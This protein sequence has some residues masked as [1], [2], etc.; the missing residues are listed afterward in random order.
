MQGAGVSVD[1]GTILCVDD[2]A[3]LADLIARFLEHEK[4]GFQTVTAN[5][6]AEART[7]L[8]ERDVDCIVCDYRMPEEDGLAFLRDLRESGVDLPFI[9]YTAQGSE[10]V[11]SDAIA[12]GVTDYLQKRPDRNQFE[13]L[14]NRI[15]RW[16]AEYRANQERELTIERMTEAIIE[17]DSDWRFTMVDDRAAEYLGLDRVSTLGERIWDVLPRATEAEFYHACETVLETGEPATVEE[18]YAEMDRWFSID[19][20][21]GV[22]DGL[23]IYFKDVSEQKLRERRQAALTETLKELLQASTPEEACTVVSE[24]AAPALPTATLGIALFDDQRISLELRTATGDGEDTIEQLNLLREGGAAWEAVVEGDVVFV[25]VDHPVGDEPAVS[26]FVVLPLG[27]HGAILYGFRNRVESTDDV[28]DVLY[29]L[30]N[31]LHVALDRLAKEAQLRARDDRLE[32]QNRVLERL[33]R[34]NEVIRNIH[35]RLIDAKSRADV[36]RAIC[37]ELGDSGQYRFVWIGVLDRKS[38]RVVPKA[39]AGEEKGYLDAIDLALSGDETSDWPV[40]RAIETH[41]LQAVPEIYEG[42]SIQG[43]RKAAFRRGFRSKIVVP[44]VFRDRLYGVLNAHID[45]PK[46]FDDLEKEVL[47]ELGETTG[48]AINALDRKRALLSD[49]VVELQLRLDAGSIPLLE[50]IVETNGHIEI[51][52]VV[53]AEDDTYRVFVTLESCP[54]ERL[55]EFVGGSPLVLQSTHVASEGDRETYEW[56][57]TGESLFGW[58]LDYGVVPVSVTARDEDCTVVLELPEE[59]DVGQFVSNL[60]SV[61][62]VLELVSRRDTERSV[63]TRQEFKGSVAEQLTPR[64]QEILRTSYFNGYFESPR[65]RTG[66]EIASSLE[67]S[68]PTFNTH[69]RTALRKVVGMLYSE[70]EDDH[71]DH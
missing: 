56:V 71:Q 27:S 53:P 12:A 41:E 63:Q 66:S 36:Y 38:G 67:I 47:T 30:A 31:S 48:Y 51:E 20:Y 21:P 24:S 2:D 10:S 33:A 40:E 62:P 19:V 37:E 52:H 43:W 42:P 46:E 55:L 57:V 61:Y 58:L 60:D 35:Q 25:D 68:Q 29:Q 15:T 32:E 1:S 22:T 23:S 17:I 65:N 34:I 14:A 9:L 50:P 18:Y 7:R 64:Q 11:A 70:D 39:S 44:I 26:Q 59:E 49:K 4:S 28:L 3:E 45:R 8:E 5:S 69:L 13:L 16:I 54:E 6:A